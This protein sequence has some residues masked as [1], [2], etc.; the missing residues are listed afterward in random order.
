VENIQAIRQEP[1]QDATDDLPSEAKENRRDPFWKFGVLVPRTRAPAVEINKKN[2]NTHWQDALV[3]E[4][5]QLLEYNT[6]V[7]KGKGGTPPA[8]YKRIR[9]HMIYDVKHDGRHKA[10]LVASGHLTDPNTESVYSGFVSLRGKWLIV[11]LEEL[12]LLDPWGANVG[13]AYLEANTKESAYIIGRPDF[14]PLEGHVLIIFK[15][16]YGLRSSGLCW[17][18]RLSDVLRVF[19]FNPT[20][21]EAEIL[22]RENNGLY[23]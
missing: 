12:K 23:E 21:A 15:A 11:F 6:F 10:R 4:M 22:M 2:G 14:G 17:Y 19:G 20:K 16:F 5:K 3:T 7:N 1:K 9:C 13:N 18:Q 8:G